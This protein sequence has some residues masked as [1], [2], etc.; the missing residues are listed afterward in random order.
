MGEAVRFGSI[1]KVALDGVWEYTQE[2]GPRVD[3]RAVGP[4]HLAHDGSVS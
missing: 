4:E 3:P 2:P 1:L